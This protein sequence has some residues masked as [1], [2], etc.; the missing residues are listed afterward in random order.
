MSFSI[1]PALPIWKGPLQPLTQHVLT[2]HLVKARHS[3]TGSTRHVPSWRSVHKVCFWKNLREETCLKGSF[4]AQNLNFPTVLNP[5]SLHR[6]VGRSRL[7][8]SPYTMTSAGPGHPAP[9][10]NISSFLILRKGRSEGGI[11]RSRATGTRD[12]GEPSP[13]AQGSRETRPHSRPS[14]SPGS[15]VP[16]HRPL[17]GGLR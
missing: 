1:I 13:E 9:L 16:A 12:R 17:P 10:Q 15:P 2:W 4:V 5:C 14:P 6:E 3:C 8:H 11:R 7:G